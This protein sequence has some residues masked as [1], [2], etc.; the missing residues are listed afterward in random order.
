MQ[1][2][3]NGI[4][5]ICIENLKRLFIIYGYDRKGVAS[6]FLVLLPCKVSGMNI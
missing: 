4:T 3:R 1:R 2:K 5:Y 6:S